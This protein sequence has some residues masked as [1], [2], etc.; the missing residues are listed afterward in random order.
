MNRENYTPCDSAE[1][2]TDDEVIIEYL[3]SAAWGQRPLTERS[4]AQ[5]SASKTAVPYLTQTSR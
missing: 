1:I 2:L 3:R 4:D 5:C